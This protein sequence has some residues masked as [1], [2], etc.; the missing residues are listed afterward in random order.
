M[1]K[2]SGIRY[3]KII[4][5]DNEQWIE[6]GEEPS[7]D[8]CVINNK[9]NNNQQC[10]DGTMVSMNLDRKKENVSDIAVVDERLKTEIMIKVSFPIYRQNR[11]DNMHTKQGRI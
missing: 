1:K 6:E 11:Y 9:K 5:F 7:K 4:I 8:F 2:K 10:K 3:L